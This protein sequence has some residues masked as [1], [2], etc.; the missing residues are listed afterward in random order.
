MVDLNALIGEEL[1]R[2]MD[3]FMNEGLGR[4][5]YAEMEI[6]SR[7]WIADLHDTFSESTI[8]TV[9]YES[10]MYVERRDLWVDYLN[11]QTGKKTRLQVLDVL[12]SWKKPF[13][14]MAEVVD[15]K[16]RVIYLLDGLS[17]QTYTIDGDESPMKGDWLFGVVMPDFRDG[18][19]SLRGTNGLIFIPKR[20]KALIKA[21]ME[22][23][24][25]FN[26]D[27]LSLY[28]LFAEFDQ[29]N[30]FTTFE[31]EV[32]KLVSGYLQEFGVKGNGMMKLVQAFLLNVSGNAKK[33]GA[34]A[35]GLVQAALD[36]GLIKPSEMSQKELVAYFGVSI[37][38]MTKY[39]EMVG[40]F[41][42]HSLKRMESKTTQAK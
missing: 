18:Q 39:R 7:A 21:L 1:D 10:F 37:T 12:E 20:R 35:A 27:V 30:G 3:G 8:K 32:V 40:D 6:R 14:L 29:G 41:I 31:Q 28:R 24:K 19:Q 23:L 25:A 22:E 42:A 9:S 13:W 33:S 17:E 36:Y 4:R 16:G 11:R 26:G 5:E 2:V 38:T 34:V 15:Q